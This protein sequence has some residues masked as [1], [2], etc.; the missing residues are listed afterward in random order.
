MIGTKVSGP[1]DRYLPVMIGEQKRSCTRSP[2]Y[3]ELGVLLAPA[4]V[5]RPIF[6]FE[7]PFKSG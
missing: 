2:H 7:N 3:F 6:G 4:S 5:L 1:I